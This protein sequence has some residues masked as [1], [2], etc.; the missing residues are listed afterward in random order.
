[1]DTGRFNRSFRGITYTSLEEAREA[2]Q[3]EESRSFR[4]KG[5]AKDVGIQQIHGVSSQHGIN[6]S[7]AEL[8]LGKLII[9][10]AHDTKYVGL[11][12]MLIDGNEIKRV[13]R[14]IIETGR[15]G[16]C[17]YSGQEST[18]PPKT[19]SD[20]KKHNLTIINSIKSGNGLAIL[21]FKCGGY[22][23]VNTNM[24]MS[25]LKEDALKLL[26]ELN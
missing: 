26:I 24:K 17:Q 16:K 7:T 4:L 13:G 8:T 5:K 23:Y 1:M 25:F 22:I 20:T 11:D 3:A 21:C 9:Y 18:S 10:C 15:T 2:F 19:D 14:D 12:T 6:V